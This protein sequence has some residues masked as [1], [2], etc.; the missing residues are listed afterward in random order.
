MVLGPHPGGSGDFP[1]WTEPA[2]FGC[3]K[4]GNDRLRVPLSPDL[5]GPERKAEIRA[6]SSS[7]LHLSQLPS[8]YPL[9]GRYGCV[10]LARRGSAL[11]MSKCSC[12]AK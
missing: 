12:E 1:E 7:S 6:G 4:P 11:R 10:M 3:G 2:V 8:R 9:M 5:P